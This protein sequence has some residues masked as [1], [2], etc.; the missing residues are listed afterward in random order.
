MSRRSNGPWLS[1]GWSLH[2]TSHEQKDMR[3]Q[4]AVALEEITI[5]QKVLVKRKEK[6]RTRKVDVIHKQQEVTLTQEEEASML[7][8]ESHEPYEPYDE[9]YGDYEYE[10]GTTY[11]EES[12]EGG[13]AH[14]SPALLTAKDEKHLTPI[15]DMEASHFL[16]TVS[17]LTAEEAELATRVHLRVAN[18]A[19]HLSP[20]ILRLRSTG[21][22][23]CLM[24]DGQT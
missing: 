8:G 19:D 9:S 12:P 4:N 22:E 6:A 2:P 24:E 3:L 17:H 10:E 11:P 1:K 13:T 21:M 18:G 5:T 20:N 16:L 7:N 15:L 23:R 14:L